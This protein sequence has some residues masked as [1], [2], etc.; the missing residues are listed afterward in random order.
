MRILFVTSS[1]INGGAQ[2]HIRDM[3]RCLSESGNDVYLAAP[4]GWLTDEL[5]KYS[6]KIYK[7]NVD[8]HTIHELSSIFDAVKPDITNT[9]ILSGGVFGTLSW[10]KRKYGK[11]FV[12]VNNPIIY[13]GISRKGKIL[14]PLFYKWMAKYANAF[15]VK[16]DKVRD[17]VEETINSKKPVISIKNG[18][19]FSIFDK[20]AMYLNLRNDLGISDNE[21]VITNVAVLD[22]RKGQ[23]HLIEAV[24]NLHTKYPV[25]LLLVGEGPYRGRL[26]KKI[27]DLRAES[28]IHLIGRRSDVNCVLANSDIFVLSS[29]HEGLPN[30]LMEAMSMAIPCIATDVGGVRQ[31][32]TNSNEGV[33]IQARNSDQIVKAVEFLLNNREKMRE[34]GKYGY[35]RI[36][37]E[38]EQS[39]VASE[40]LEIYHKF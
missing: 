11:L 4:E 16:S 9:F 26:E 1:S 38:Y 8:F 32:I 21:I 27:L 30:A 29:F 18:I 15:L 37:N 40:L 3:F 33:V 28:Y 31:L 35:M 13:D 24:N 23:M 7:I 14:Y 12:T 25:Q 20:D 17:E 10:K 22:E 6:K 39:K 36:K 5:A 19:D 2:K 34:V